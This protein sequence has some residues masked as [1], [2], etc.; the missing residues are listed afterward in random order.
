ME[1]WLFDSKVNRLGLVTISKKKDILRDLRINQRTRFKDL[2]FR[3]IEVN[4]ADTKD[5]FNKNRK[6]E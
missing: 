3:I 5:S 4:I 1:I 6:I 2:I